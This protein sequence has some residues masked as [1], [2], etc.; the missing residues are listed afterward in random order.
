MW[1]FYWK[2]QEAGNKNYFAALIE[3]EARKLTLFLVQQA[4]KQVQARNKKNNNVTMLFSRCMYTNLL[5]TS[6]PQNVL[7]YNVKLKY[8]AACCGGSHHHR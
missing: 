6:W 8:I 4:V 2:N 1:N 3:M 7:K 5:S